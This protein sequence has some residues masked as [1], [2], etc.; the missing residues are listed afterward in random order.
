MFGHWELIVLLVV[1][2][3]IFGPSQLPK[4]AKGIGKS[5]QSFKS[6]MKDSQQEEESKSPK[7]VGAG[8]EKKELPGKGKDDE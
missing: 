4:L 5:I 7:E 8:E 2:L 6:G 3:L 1:V